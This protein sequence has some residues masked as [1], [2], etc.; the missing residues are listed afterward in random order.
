MW[1]VRRSFPEC[2]TH[3]VLELVGSVLRLPSWI[4]A[5]QR[6][7]V[8]E[9]QAQENFRHDSSADRTKL[10]S[11]D[12]NLFLHRNF[13]FYLWGL[14]GLCQDIGPERTVFPKHGTDCV[15]ANGRWIAGVLFVHAFAD[16]DVLILHDWH[17]H[18]SSNLLPRWK[19]QA[20]RPLK[21]ALREGRGVGCNDGGKIGKRIHDGGIDAI[22]KL[23]SLLILI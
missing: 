21:I 16:N 23:E 7:V 20:P 10:R 2:V 3:E 9:H 19:T 1:R 5:E 11:S 8:P 13:D 22:G 4:R 15:N 17:T 6:M 14:H 18:R 12:R